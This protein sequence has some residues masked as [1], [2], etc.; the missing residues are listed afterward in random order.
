MATRLAESECRICK[1]TSHR[2]EGG[3][4]DWGV[5]WDAWRAH[6]DELTFDEQAR[7]AL[8]VHR[9][10]PEQKHWNM[11]AWNQFL[12]TLRPRSVVEIGG[13][14]G[15]LAAYTLEKRSGIGLW[16]NCELLPIVREISICHDD[17]YWPYPLTEFLWEYRWWPERIPDLFVA[18]HTIEHMRLEEVAGI[19]DLVQARHVYFEAPLTDASRQS[20]EGYS[21]THILEAGWIDVDQMMRQRGYSV[22]IYDEGCH[23]YKR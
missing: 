3:P 2:W 12:K 9:E 23:G 20:W 14:N 22:A 8:R 13:Y 21:A 1:P 16:M 5:V 17:R 15:S 10:Y 18:T 6:Y 11:Q 19:I 7:F 4:S